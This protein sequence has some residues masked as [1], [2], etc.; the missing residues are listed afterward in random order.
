MSYPSPDRSRLSRRA[1]G[2]AVATAALALVA[3]CGNGDDSTATPAAAGSSSGPAAFPVSIQHKYGTTDITKAPERIVV[4]G[5]VEQDALLA[6]G[7]VPVATTEWFGEKP[8]AIQSWAK[9]KLGSAP[10]PQVLTNT[11][12]VQFEKVAALKPDLII[13]L[14]SGMTKEDYATLSKIAPTLAQPSG[15]TDFGVGWDVVTQTVGKAVGKSAE[16]DKIVADTTALF[17]A[18]TAAHPTFKGASA[19]FATTYEGYYVYG[20]EDARGRFLQSLGFVLPADLASVTGKDFGANISK[21]RIDLLNTDVLVWLVDDYAKDKATVQNDPLYSALKVKKEGRDI[22]LTNTEEL[23]NASSFVTV[24]SLP[25]LLD[26]LVPQLAEAIDGNP[27]TPV[28]RA[29]AS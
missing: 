8:G 20:P 25:F 27:A 5:L 12:G 9:D 29:T 14:Y 28:V 10:V 23:G 2:G 16:A 13:G 4:V 21:E 3:A 6:L 24:L 19:L 26:G 17:T 11:D 7:V 18:A 15:V 22:F 1:F